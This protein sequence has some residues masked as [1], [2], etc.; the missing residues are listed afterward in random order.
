MCRVGCKITHSL[1]LLLLPFA[2]LSSD[3]QT[4]EWTRAISLAGLLQAC[5]HLCHW[6]DHIRAQNECEVTVVLV[7]LQITAVMNSNWWNVFVI[8]VRAFV[9]HSGYPP[10]QSASVLSFTESSCEPSLEIPAEPATRYPCSASDH[11]LSQP[12]RS[13]STRLGLE[14]VHVSCCLDF[15]S[16]E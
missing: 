8:R 3:T 6:T 2:E 10:D 11:R 15:T 14:N 1:L 12:D 5:C 7:V 9:L 4:P 16:A 13:P